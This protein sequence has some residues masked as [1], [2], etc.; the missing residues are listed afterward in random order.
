MHTPPGAFLFLSTALADRIVRAT[1]TQTSRFARNGQ[2]GALAHSLTLTPFT[3]LFGPFA[4]HVV[5]SPQTHF[6]DTPGCVHSAIAGRSFRLS[7]VSS[8]VVTYSMTDSV[9]DAAG[10]TMLDSSPCLCGGRLSLGVAPESDP[11]AIQIAAEQCHTGYDPG[12]PQPK[13][14]TFSL[15]SSGGES[16]A[17]MP[18][19][20]HHALAPV[21]RARFC[22][23]TRPT[24]AP[25]PRFTCSRTR[26]T[27]NGS[28]GARCGGR[29]RRARR[30]RSGS[31]RGGPG[32]P[33]SM[34]AR[35]GRGRASAGQTGAGS[36]LFPTGDNRSS[37]SR[38]PNDGDLEMTESRRREGRSSKYTISA[39]CSP[40]TRA[41]RTAAPSCRRRSVTFFQ[42]L[43]AGGAGG[44]N[45]HGS[46]RAQGTGGAASEE[47]GFSLFQ[48]SPTV[49]VCVQGKP[50]W[51]PCSAV[52]TP[53]HRNALGSYA[54]TEL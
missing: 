12:A 39:T 7:A 17:P 20:T 53:W 51:A 46:R 54:T 4:R 40:P 41:I 43:A 9:E 28:V 22:G 32:E 48:G 45:S 15:L 49:C 19:P 44:P 42:R 2:S 18:G 29:S 3:P 8:C 11:M 31:G 14:G 47:S 13:E 50:V 1:A 6:I 37:A 10:A 35:V 27:L 34:H 33:R 26:I 5:G 30:E 25:L 23:A 52:A 16:P 21:G 36:R 38:P 24:W